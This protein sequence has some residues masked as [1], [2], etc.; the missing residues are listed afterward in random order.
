MT[1]KMKRLLAD[2]CLTFESALNI[3]VV[4]TLSGTAPG[5]G[6]AIDNMRMEEVIGCVAGDNTVLVVAK[7]EEAA[8]TAVERLRNISR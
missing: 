7:S 1:E 8:Q 6:E 5:V 2:C 4:K 3:V